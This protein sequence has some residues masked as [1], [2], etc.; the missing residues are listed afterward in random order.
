MKNVEETLAKYEKR[1]TG[2]CVTPLRSGY[3]PETG[4]LSEL[5]ADGLQYYQDLIGVL[6]WIVKLVRVDIFLETS[7]MSAHLALTR[8]GHLEQ[9]FHMFGYLKLHPK[10]KIV[11]DAAHPS[12][13]ERRFKKYNWYEFYRGAKEAIPLDFPEALGN[14]ISTHCFVDVYLSDNLISRIS[15]TGVLIFLIGHP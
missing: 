8:I 14:S 12:I 6:R 4:D 7:L 5:K 2:H 10:R 9:V 13:Y 15:Q 1:L 3:R 11:F